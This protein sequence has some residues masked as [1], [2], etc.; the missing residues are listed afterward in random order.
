[1]AFFKKIRICGFVEVVVAL[2]E[3][4]CHWGWV[5]FEF[6]K[7][8]PRPV[9]YSFFPLPVDPD[10]ELLAPS[11]APCLPAHHQYPTMMTIDKASEL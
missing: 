9:P 4:V 6:Q 11:P 10:V 2:L 7:L 1:M 8:K 5:G 3:E